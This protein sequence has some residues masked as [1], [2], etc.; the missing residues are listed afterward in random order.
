M[1]LTF[2]RDQ[3]EG[4]LRQLGELLVR[5]GVRA[6]ITVVGGSA[7]ALACAD[8]RVTRDVDA[9]FRPREVVA[10]LA[11]EV[12]HANGLP[13]GWLSDAVATV[14]PEFTDPDPRVVWQADGVSVEVVSP[15][16]LLAMKA[17]ASRQSRADLEDAARLC[18]LLGIRDEPAL[19]RLIRS[20]VPSVAPF[21]AQELFFEDII[22]R[23]R[24]LASGPGEGSPRPPEVVST[25][26][27]CEHWLPVARRRC[28][29]PSG[30]RGQHR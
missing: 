21:G 11:A 27:L 9:Y 29:L 24:V 15:G 18:G 23:A 17:M 28:G 1:D 19:E 2:G 13:E 20:N 8:V 25:S 4:L 16:Y 3:V 22:E 10:R 14:W 7:M 12:A 6:R 5:D 26:P 30:H